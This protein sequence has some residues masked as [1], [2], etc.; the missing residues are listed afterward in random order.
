MDQPNAVLTWSPATPDNGCS[1]RGKNGTR[2][3]ARRGPF[4]YSRNLVPFL[5][6]VGCAAGR[7]AALRAVRNSARCILRPRG[8]RS[9]RPVPQRMTEQSSWD[10]ALGR[11]PSFKVSLLRFLWKECKPLGTRTRRGRSVRVIAAWNRPLRNCGRKERISPRPL[12]Q[13]TADSS[14][15]SRRFATGRKGYPGN[16]EF[17]AK[18]YY[19]IGIPVRIAGISNDRSS[20]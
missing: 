20:A 14:S 8:R 6:R 16:S 11:S 4:A 18:K 2:Q 7:L 1:V 9:A 13:F 12:L 3:G 17:A 19:R 5:A 15:S 10:E